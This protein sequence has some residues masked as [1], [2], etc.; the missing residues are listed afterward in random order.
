MGID[1]AIR[2]RKQLKQ[3]NQNDKPGKDQ[4]NCV[5]DMRKSFFHQDQPLFAAACFELLLYFSYCISQTPS[6]Y[7][8]AQKKKSRAPKQIEQ[9]QNF[10]QLETFS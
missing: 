5:F 3:K 1:L 6:A 8:F 9:L 7:P 4:A 2:S 10:F